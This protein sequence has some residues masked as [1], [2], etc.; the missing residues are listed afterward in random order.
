ME[1]SWI[2]SIVVGGFLLVIGLVFKESIKELLKHWGWTTF[3]IYRWDAL[4]ERWKDR[5]RWEGLRGLWWLWSILGL[6]G[7]LLLALWLIPQPPPLAA[8]EPRLGS[9][10]E[11][12]QTQ[13]ETTSRERD[14]LREQVGALEQK[15]GSLGLFTERLG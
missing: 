3:L 7:G 5:F 8:P 13:L 10:I 2:A 1:I 14:A 11:T 6:S 12:L 4:P 15:L 9:Q